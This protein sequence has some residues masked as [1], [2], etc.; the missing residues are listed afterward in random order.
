MA[1]MAHAPA[2]APLNMTFGAGSIGYCNPFTSVFFIC[3]LEHLQAN[4]K[5]ESVPPVAGFH[6]SWNNLPALGYG[7]Y[8]GYQ[9]G[10]GVKPLLY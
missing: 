8:G 2:I 7:G 1:N 5:Y 6:F 3:V 9:G 10:Y 4:M